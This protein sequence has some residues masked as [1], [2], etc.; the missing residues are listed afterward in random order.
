MKHLSCKKGSP[1]AFTLIELLVVIAIIAILAAILLPALA[2]AKSRAYAATDI[3]NCRQTMIATAMYCTDNNDYLPSPGWQVVA[4]CWITCANPPDMTSPHAA[5]N[6]QRD[7]DQQVSWFNG[8]TALEPGS[9]KPPRSGLL[10]QYLKEPQL[11]LCPQDLVNANYLKREELISSYVWNGAVV[12]Y[13]NGAPSMRIIKFKPTNIL[14]W[15]NDENNTSAG[16]WGDFSNYPAEA[17]AAGVQQPNFSQRH[18]KAAQIGRMDGSAGR[19]PYVN[20]AAWAKSTATKNDL[21]CNP[22]SA[23]GH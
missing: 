1:R 18:G 20:M 7:Y 22:N 6:Y 5:Q 4:D 2:S 21:W 9:P 3:N 15:E 12:G 10:Y 14:Q 19:E 17:N 8:I 13:Q 11:F 16:N 23:N